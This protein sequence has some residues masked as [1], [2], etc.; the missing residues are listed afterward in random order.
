VCSSDLVAERDVD[1]VLDASGFAL[2]DQWG[3]KMA[4]HLGHKLEEARRRGAYVI[5]LPQA[6]GPFTKPAV[7]AASQDVM[8]KVDLVFARE[9]QSYDYLM[10]LGIDA[11]KARIAPDFTNG[12]EVASV[13]TQ[14]SVPGDEGYAR[15][16]CVVPNYRMVDM[17]ADGVEDAYIEFLCDTVRTL[18]KNDLDVQVLLHTSNPNDAD[19]GRTV[20]RRTGADLLAP[21]DALDVKRVIGASECVVSS[22]FHGL[23]NA[24][25]QGVP[26]AATGWSHKYQYLMREYD[27]EE[28][29]VSM[30][31]PASNQQ[32]D[33]QALIDQRDTLRDRIETAGAVQ[34]QRTAEMWS[35]V[36]AAINRR[37]PD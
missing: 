22:R 28:F 7:R 11:S 30:D 5:M 32:A 13:D 31:A 35:D 8:E 1:V 17:T 19:L 12:L 37:V 36:R 23:V 34:K 2:S 33:I 24:L 10:D 20:C 27:C 4:I 9:Q 21:T 14:L 15:Y 3:P 18:S 25:S 29:L 6:F 16:A 26:A